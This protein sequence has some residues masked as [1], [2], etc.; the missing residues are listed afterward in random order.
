MEDELFEV[1]NKNYQLAAFAIEGQFELYLYVNKKSD[2]AM[3]VFGERIN[4]KLKVFGAYGIS[5]VI[6][7][8]VAKAISEILNLMIKYISQEQATR[9]INKIIS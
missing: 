4:N 2:G 3:Y 9:M 7:T 6:T 5:D 8:S 1:L